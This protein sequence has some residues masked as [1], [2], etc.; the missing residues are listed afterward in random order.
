[1]PVGDLTVDPII[2]KTVGDLEVPQWEMAAGMAAPRVPELG[3][4][5]TADVL[6]APRMGAKSFPEAVVLDP[7][8][9][10]SALNEL[11][12]APDVGFGVFNK[13]TGGI[14]G[15]VLG[16]AGGLAD[17]FVPQPIKD[18]GNEAAKKFDS[19]AQ[20]S[21]A[22]WGKRIGNVFNSPD[23][24]YG[25]D[26]FTSGKRSLLGG[27]DKLTFFGGQNLGEDVTDAAKMVASAL[28]LLK[29]P[30]YIAGAL[31][32]ARLGGVAEAAGGYAGAFKNTFRGA[33]VV[34]ETTAAAYGRF[35]GLA[36]LGATGVGVAAEVVLPKVA[37]NEPWAQDLLKTRLIPE[38]SPWR[39]PFEI[40]TTLP[41]D[42]PSLL[43]AGKESRVMG[44]ASTRLFGPGRNPATHVWPKWRE[45][46]NRGVLTTEDVNDF[47]KH[48]VSQ[49]AKKSLL[50][51]AA[52]REAA[53]FTEIGQLPRVRAM[54][55]TL[56]IT[57][58][59]AA[60]KLISERIGDL[61]KTKGTNTLH[62]EAAEWARDEYHGWTGLDT[63]SQM[64][65]WQEFR[66]TVLPLQQQFPDMVL[67]IN[68]AKQF[69]QRDSAVAWLNEAPTFGLTDRA[70]FAENFPSL[71]DM[72][73][74][75][76]TK[77]ELLQKLNDL[78]VPDNMPRTSEL[79]RLGSLRSQLERVN[80]SILGGDT[81]LRPQRAQ[82]L[83]E[84]KTV[85]DSAV[86]YHSN[87]LKALEA[88]Y[89]RREMELWTLGE[90]S[91]GA[92]SI[93]GQELDAL[94]AAIRDTRAAMH[95]ASLAGTRWQLEYFTSGPRMRL[96]DDLG[97]RV[98]AQ[99]RTTAGRIW[100]N[101]FGALPNKD[102]SMRAEKSLYEEAGRRGA[103]PTQV[104]RFMALAS[105]FLDTTSHNTVLGFKRHQYTSIYSLP[106]GELNA[107][108]TKAG[109]PAGSKT[110]SEA[111][112]RAYPGSLK[113]LQEGITGGKAIDVPFYS[114][115]LHY[116]S[117]SLYPMFR[118]YLSPRFVL[119]NLQERNILGTTMGGKDYHG[120][121]DPRLERLNTRGLKDEAAGNTGFVDIDALPSEL[122]RLTGQLS[123]DLIARNVVEV[124]R[125]SPQMEDALRSAGVNPKNVKEV[126]K[127]LDG[128]TAERM[129]ALTFDVPLTTRE[130][131]TKARIDELKAR[132]GDQ[133]SGADLADRTELEKLSQ[134]LTASIVKR[135]VREAAAS[136][137]GGESLGYAELTLQ[138]AVSRAEFEARD[139]AR[140]IFLG[141]PD[142][143]AL[144]R[145]LNSYLLYWPLSYQ[146]KV[147]RSL[148]GFLTGRAFNLPTG[149]APAMVWNKLYQDAQSDP[150]TVAWMK[151]H[152]AELF[153][154]QQLLPITPD[155][156]GVTLSPFTRL[157][158]SAVGLGSD[159]S[160]KLIDRISSQGFNYDVRLTQQVWAELQKNL[161]GK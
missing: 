16:A 143:S 117:R 94:G 32:A 62:R 69:M 71:K 72:A 33:R 88:Q 13:L 57:E 52:N 12:H 4:R 48:S 152:K 19:L 142:R 110:W 44:E 128:V 43:S 28:I 101:L 9:I 127:Y 55:K 93:V 158:G 46:V 147:G 140:R 25:F 41:L 138:N 89:A 154:F 106:P 78:P 76:K 36:T 38:D 121:V 27:N 155:S 144:E 47:N 79:G 23:G 21:M 35:A 115:N 99:E 111:M 26:A 63:A 146:L 107:L 159:P 29:S 160:K 109:I 65:Q 24:Q 75:V 86:A 134:E 40:A 8:L 73:A 116:V 151:Q 102:L 17:K 1:M 5:F 10:T 15:N 3:Q 124:L 149:S 34:E 30:G 113:L 90:H 56:G 74:K 97:V 161:S 6:P 87:Q 131:P 126:I 103:T 156:L 61:Y 85:R 77:D 22:L 104:D 59:E 60:N 53:T 95:D 112:Y 31:R 118:F 51:D 2:P 153:L 130:L 50:D 120:P 68:D 37:G 135:Q 132:I 105:D 45:A 84:M 125:K 100:D 137:N 141:N 70:R 39:F 123:P 157:A 108:A 98:S 148:F 92:A 7:N 64:G 54:A 96:A 139:S 91:P 42:L 81:S 150:E 122:A 129:K 49:Y 20:D 133:G 67:S 80:S 83:S 58:Q 82:I 14:A 114:Q 119:I 66:N 145:G 136:L 11:G 18:F